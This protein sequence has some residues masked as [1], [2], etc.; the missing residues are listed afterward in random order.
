MPWHY[1][2]QAHLLDTLVDAQSVNPTPERVDS[3]L[4]IRGHLTRNNGRWTNNYYDDAWPGSHWPWNEPAA[5]PGVPKTP[6]RCP[7]CPL[8]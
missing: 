3:I 6:R 8:S 2:W 5:S 4:W 1:W 7:P